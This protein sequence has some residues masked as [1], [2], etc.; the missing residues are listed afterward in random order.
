[1]ARVIADLAPDEAY[2]D[3]SDVKEWRYGQHIRGCLPTGLRGIRICSEH[4][5]D[6]TYPAVSAASIIAKVRRDEVVADLRK[7]YGDFGSGYITPKTLHFLRDWRR[8]HSQYPPIVRVSWKTISE[9]EA[10]MCQGRLDE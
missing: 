6:R 9:I 7:E 1:M 2:V 8:C 10:E 3:A 5:A 4:Y